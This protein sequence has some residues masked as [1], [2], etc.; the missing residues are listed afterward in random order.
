MDCK[1]CRNVMLTFC[2]L[3]R[4]EVLRRRQNDSYELAASGYCIAATEGKSRLFLRFLCF[5]FSPS[6]RVH[7]ITSGADIW[8]DGEKKSRVV[9]RGGGKRGG[10]RQKSES[11]PCSGLSNFKARDSIPGKMQPLILKSL[12]QLSGDD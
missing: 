1:S 10:E 2:H 8:S 3:S 11:N 12:V 9:S 4:Y 7:S 6:A 5:P